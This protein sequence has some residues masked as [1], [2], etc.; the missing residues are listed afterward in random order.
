M[1][2]IS[3][4]NCMSKLNSPR[5]LSVSV[6]LQ[7]LIL[8]SLY[9]SSVCDFYNHQFNKMTATFLTN[10]IPLHPERY[11]DPQ[12]RKLATVVDKKLSSIENSSQKERIIKKPYDNSWQIYLKI[13]TS[14][15]GIII[16]ILGLLDRMRDQKR[17]VPAPC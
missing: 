12:V 2:T 9:G 8:I 15:A 5:I 3:F 13:S 7:F 17:K 6:L 1:K 10:R 16:F 4:F 14:S 11:T